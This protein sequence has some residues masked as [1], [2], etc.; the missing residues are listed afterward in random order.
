MRCFFEMGKVYV[1]VKREKRYLSLSGWA[2]S[3]FDFMPAETKS[4]LSWKVN[5]R[6]VFSLGHA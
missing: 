2:R 4:P 3:F 1:V 5:F 6:F